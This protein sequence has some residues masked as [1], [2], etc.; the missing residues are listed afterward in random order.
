[1]SANFVGIIFADSDGIAGMKEL[2]FKRTLAAV[3][4][5]ARYRLVDF[6]LSNMTHA[7]AKNI[8]IIV[9]QSYQS[10]MNHVASG[11][12]WDL[13]R[14]YSGLWILPPFATENNVDTLYKHEL[15]G[16][17]AN[18]TFLKNLDEE[19]VLITESNT[20]ANID[21]ARAVEEHIASGRAISL[22]YTKKPRVAAP[23]V[24]RTFLR[25]GA[26]HLVTDLIIGEEAPDDY[27]CGLNTVI[28]KRKDMISI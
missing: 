22:L 15:E 1:M 16:L 19:Y 3:P 8:G 24:S 28:L 2:L 4:F 20:V 14:K 5:A 27:V 25:V 13:D 10:L 7:G 6:P 18:R 21:Y 17:I 11:A 9:K 26:D 23:G 12:A